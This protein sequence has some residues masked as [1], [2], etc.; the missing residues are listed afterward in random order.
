[1]RAE[2]AVLVVAVALALAV[3]RT[4]RAQQ[5]DMAAVMLPLVLPGVVTDLV[6]G[7]ELLGD[8]HAGLGWSIAGTVFWSLYLTLDVALLVDEL[9]TSGL[10]PFPWFTG[11]M[12]V[13][14]TASLAT[15]ID[16]ILHPP[17]VT[18]APAA[19]A[20][21]GGRLAPGLVVSGHF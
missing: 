21:S 8:G 19:L 10:Q 6:V 14:G 11:G 20:S 3:P 2:R 7:G 4:A 13:V 18:V 15:S 1:M 16:G 9:R 5:V 17:P 12:L